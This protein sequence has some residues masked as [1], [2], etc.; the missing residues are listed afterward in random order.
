M[1]ASV[2]VTC[3]V[4]CWQH[5]QVRFLFAG[6]WYRAVPPIVIR[7]VCLCGFNVFFFL[8]IN[9]KA[10]RSRWEVRCALAVPTNCNTWFSFGHSAS[11]TAVVRQR[12]ADGD[13]RNE[14]EWSCDRWVC[15]WCDWIV[16]CVYLHV[17]DECSHSMW[18]HNRKIKWSATQYS[19]KCP[20]MG[21]MLSPEC[22]WVCAVHCLSVCV[23]TVWHTCAI[24]QEGINDHRQPVCGTK[25]TC[26]N[27]LPIRGYR[28]FVY[29]PLAP[30]QFSTVGQRPVATAYVTY[31]RTA[32]LSLWRTSPDPPMTQ[33]IT[34]D[35]GICLTSLWTF[36]DFIREINSKKHIS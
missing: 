23:R 11:W 15:V 25:K 29:T 33:S 30:S 14:R 32:N 6:T 20:A 19:G 28:G 7:C 13:G 35:Y 10:K 24:E 21:R 36:F 27:S 22:V 1:G 12:Q 8:S 3:D 5:T 26:M 31:V 17:F 9:R 34:D 2:C 16:V 18:P 4:W